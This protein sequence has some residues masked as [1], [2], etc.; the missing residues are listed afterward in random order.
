MTDLEKAWIQDI[1]RQLEEDK[2]VNPPCGSDRFD[3]ETHTITAR[4]RQLN[5]TW[6]IEAPQDLQAIYGVREEEV[7]DHIA[8]ELRHEIDQQL[9]ERI[10]EGAEQA[11]EAENREQ[12]RDAFFAALDRP[13]SPMRSGEID[14]D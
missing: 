5:A 3:I 9:V 1:R 10:M 7:M 8:E 11:R 6:T 12:F 14:D 4:P 13:P 2:I